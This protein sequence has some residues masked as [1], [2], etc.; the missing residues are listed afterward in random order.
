MDM[1]NKVALVILDGWG[2]GRPE[3]ANAI[4]TANTPVMDSLLAKYPHSSLLTHAEYVGLPDGQMGNS[5]V[6]HLNIGA[7]RVVY[8]DLVR[9]NKAIE[10]GEL[11]QNVALKSAIARV[12]KSGCRLHLLGLVSTGGVHS[13]QKH[14]E[15]LCQISDS[16]GLENTFIHVITDGR[17]RDPHSGLGHAQELVSF[18][19]RTQSKVQIA[20]LIGRYHAM[21]RDKRWDRI[22]KAWKL[23]VKG[24][25]KPSATL[26]D[27]IRE[28]YDAG[29]S[30]EFIEPVVFQN[31]IGN[32]L[33]TMQPGDVVICFNFRTDRCREITMALTQQDFPEFGMHTLPLH[34][35]TMT[36]YDE[37]FKE[38]H[39]MFEKDNLQDTLGEVLSKAQRTQLRMAETEKYPHV[40]FFFSGGREESFAGEHRIVVPSPKVGTYD[41]QPEM[42]AYELTE[43]AIAF[44]KN[45]SPDFIC[46]NYANADMVGHTGVFDAIVKAVETVDICLGQ[47][48]EAL[49]RMEY[50][51][52]IIADHGNADYAVNPDGSPNTAHTMEPVP[53]VVISPEIN[54]V[55]DGILADVA[56]TVLKLMGLEQPGV[57]SGRSLV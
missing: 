3:P 7:G 31:E 40:T 4:W 37:T 46:I 43:E 8:Q 14:L 38:V 18:L 47:L 54:N 35:V 56:P 57:M 28:S 29:I 20:S 6:G 32:P 26:L 50:Q 11:A 30:D 27:A 24:E 55:N 42:S 23:F 15:A 49:L 12:K 44:A 9:I 36:R 19:A 22:A 39:V 51:L 53:C 21:D 48:S 25:G 45:N 17:D 34:Y 13:H 33:A 5:E 41:K 2:E 10:S 1:K 16:E 52:I